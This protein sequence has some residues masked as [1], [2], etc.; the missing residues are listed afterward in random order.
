MEHCILIAEPCEIRRIG[1][2]TV[3]A[4]APNV[5]SIHEAT[6]E[7]SLKR[8]LH[9]NVWS[10]IVVHQSLVLDVSMLPRGNFVLTTAEPDMSVLKAAYKHGARGYLS[11]KASAE[12]LRM[13]LFPVENSFLIEPLLTP[14]IMECLLGDSF[15]TIRKELLTPREREIIDLLRR[16]LDRRAVAK[17]LCIA[18]T[19]LKTHMKNI[20]RK[21]HVS[22][23]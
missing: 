18:E 13:A 22:A 3:F 23:V 9:K 4:D 21:R 10:L 14:W 15:S 5:S 2:R 6:N 1:L 17:H 19:T 12:L 16:G 20:A 7:E 11:E 8:Q